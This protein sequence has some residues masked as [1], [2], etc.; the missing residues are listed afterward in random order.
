MVAVAFLA[1]FVA[2]GFMFYS[3]GVFLG[4]VET[5]LGASR[6][7]VSWALALSNLAGSFAAPLIGRAIDRL[8]VRRVML[9]GACAVS[10]GFALAS[11]ATALWQFHLVF[12]SFLALGAMSMGNLSSGK[13]VANWF[14]ER[15]GTALGVATMGIS[16]SGLVMPPV[17]T[18]LIL[19]LGWR[20]GFLVYAAGTLLVVAPVA[21]WLVVERPEDVGQWPDG[22]ARAGGGEAPPE[23]RF[24]SRE[25]VRD[26]GFWRIVLPFALAFFANSAVLT[27]VVQ[28]ALSL[29]IPAY[30]AAFLLSC[31]A[32][33][34]VAGKV[35]FGRIADRLGPRAAVALSLSLQLAGVLLL[36]GLHRYGPLLATGLVFGFGMGG[37]VPL[38]G[39]LVAAT[40]GRVSFGKAMG[41]IRPF[42]VPIHA[43]GV[44][45]AGFVFVR[46]G[47]YG[48]AFAVFAVAYALALLALVVPSR[49]AP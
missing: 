1:D 24:A 3:F 46:T 41:L 15:R 23:R 25:I 39:T 4:A 7:Q 27:H 19:N 42:Q 30:R 44:P 17:A 49:R 45:F 8:G 6:A 26:A 16:L 32:G 13:L 10:A 5:D 37:M 14:V 36:L 2:V 43:A 22:R 11:R 35:A 12:G 21:A 40:F 20:G 48:P 33:A 9:A 34:G 28:H 31:I 47:G 29:G 38:Q 18:W